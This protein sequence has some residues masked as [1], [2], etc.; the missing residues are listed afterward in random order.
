MKY[1]EKLDKKKYTPEN[2]DKEFFTAG[3]YFLF[4][5]YGNLLYVGSSNPSKKQGE[6]T[7]PEGIKK[8][9]ENS[10]SKTQQKFQ[11][12]L[13]ITMINTQMKNNQKNLNVQHTQVQTLKF[14]NVCVC[15][16]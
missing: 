15:M 13:V 12:G 10:T 9:L 7:E 3:R 6:S 5:C 14:V 16:Q 4:D 8:N 11:S 2:I 1:F